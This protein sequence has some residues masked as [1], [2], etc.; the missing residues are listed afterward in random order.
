MTIEY[1]LP[2]SSLAVAVTYVRSVEA[3]ST[4]ASA[5]ID[6]DT[7]GPVAAAGVTAPRTTPHTTATADNARS[8][9]R[10]TRPA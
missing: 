8:E 6:S 7:D 4:V 9:S 1:P 10:R 3:G 2:T 5:L